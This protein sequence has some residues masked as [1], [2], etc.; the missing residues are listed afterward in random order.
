MGMSRSESAAPTPATAAW[1]SL[2]IVRVVVEAAV[3]LGVTLV[4]LKVQVELAGRPVQ[5]KVVAAVNPLSGV[6]DTV[7]V[8]GVPAETEG[9][10]GATVRLKSAAGGAL[11]AMESAVEVDF[12]F[13]L[14]PA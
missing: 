9:L 5:A 10:L 4:G 13:P 3:P 11:T 2:L 12:R 1:T 8:A 7:M 14:S 6:T